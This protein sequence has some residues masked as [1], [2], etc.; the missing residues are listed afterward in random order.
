MTRGFEKSIDGNLDE[1]SWT[2]TGRCE[3]DA[4]SQSLMILL[5]EL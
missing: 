5:L 1:F 4:R 3:Y 2:T